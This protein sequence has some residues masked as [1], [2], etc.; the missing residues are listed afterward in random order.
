ML[1]LVVKCLA[2]ETSCDETAVAIIDNERRI[3]AQQIYSQLDEH[4]IY[5]GVVPEIAARAH[6]QRL[7]AIIPL[8]LAEANLSLKDIDLFAATIGPGLIGGLLV[9]A[10]TAQSLA[11]A[12]DKPFIGVNHLWGHLLTPRLTDNIAYPYMALLVSGGH[13]QIIWVCGPQTGQVLGQTRDDA[14]GECFDKIAKLLGLG[15]PGGP[16]IEQQAKQ[17]TNPNRFTLPSPFLG[18]AHADFSFSGL[19]TAASQLIKK[20]IAAADIP[21][22]C[23][24]LQQAVANTVVDRLAQAIKQLK[25]NGQSPACLAVVG[26]VAANQAI[27]QALLKLCEQQQLTFIA[28]APQLCT[29]NAAMIGW[30]AIEWAQMA[31]SIREATVRPRWPV[32]AVVSK[33]Q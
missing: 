5:G 7:P 2:I 24:A 11:Y 21:D 14:A 1:K 9:G 18:Q 20:G 17:A 15:W 28:P 4:R 23:A 33:A 27:R 10:T 31:N 19:K 26:G 25:D 3:L 13:T 16:L 30:C 6:L 32:D 29:D 22:L 12:A 8:V